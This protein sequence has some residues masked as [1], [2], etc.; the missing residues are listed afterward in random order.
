VTSKRGSTGGAGVAGVA[1]WSVGSNQMLKNVG[2]ED[3]CQ[4][5]WRGFWERSHGSWRNGRSE[6]DVGGEDRGGSGR[7]EGRGTGS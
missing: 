2:S 5:A 6:R 7:K 4:R 1:R 3:C